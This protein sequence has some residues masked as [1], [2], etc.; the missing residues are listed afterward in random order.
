LLGSRAAIDQ[1]HQDLTKGMRPRPVQREKNRAAA[2]GPPI[3]V[4][5]MSS[6]V[7]LPS[8]RD[9][10]HFGILECEKRRIFGLGIGQ[11][12]SIMV[13]SGARKVAGQSHRGTDMRECWAGLA[14]VTGRNEISWVKV[15]LHQLGLS[16]DL[17]FPTPETRQVPVELAPHSGWTWRCAT[18]SLC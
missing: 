14:A 7:R 3:D 17:C 11:Y 12:D 2:V 8:S 1:W 9:A 16:K 15:N 10:E 5:S 13:E 6:T 4:W 18:S